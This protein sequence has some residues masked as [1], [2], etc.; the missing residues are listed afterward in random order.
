MQP[1]SSATLPPCV[2]RLARA[3]AWHPA[4]RRAPDPAS[5]SRLAASASTVPAALRQPTQHSG[6]LRWIVD[7][8]A[9]APSA[10]EFELLIQTLPAEDQAK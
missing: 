7:V 3:S 6:I 8:S 1:S 2:S 9:W 5:A 4:K 10:A